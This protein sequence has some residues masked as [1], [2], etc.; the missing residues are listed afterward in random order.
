[1]T[2]VIGVVAAEVQDLARPML[3]GG[4]SGRRSGGAPER[5][6]ETDLRGARPPPGWAHRRE[7]RMEKLIRWILEMA[8][9]VRDFSRA[10]PSADLNYAP[11]LAELD[12]LI[13]RLEALAK[14]QEE[15]FLVRHAGT[16]HRQAIRRELQFGLLRHLMTVVEKASKDEPGLVSRYRMPRSN[17]PKETYLTMART[18]LAHGQADREL[19]AKYGLA[20]HLLE[21]LAAALD[22]FD[23][24][25][26]ESNGGRRDHVVASSGMGTVSADLQRLVGLLDGLNRYRFGSDGELWAGWQSARKVQ[27]GPVVPESAAPAP[28]GEPTAVPGSEVKPA[29]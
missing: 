17:A 15:G 20:D 27:T 19:L 25:L 6:R 9:R 4:P 21:D 8:K 5:F 24:S 2:T 11:L 3:L 14:Q 10:H 13:E 26:V 29:A 18:M 7:R 1:M 12:L 23:A 22:G 28:G 16:L